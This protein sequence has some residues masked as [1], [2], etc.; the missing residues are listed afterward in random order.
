MR[1]K[2]RK[3]FMSIA[4]LLTFTFIILMSKLSFAA[5][6]TTNATTNLSP[7]TA[8]A[9]FLPAQT[10]AGGTMQ[11]QIDL[12]LSEG[13]HAYLKRFKLHVE[14][15]DGLKLDKFKVTPTVQFFD[16]TSNSKQEGIE[17]AAQ[18]VAT[19]E[20]PESFAD[21]TYDAEFILSYQACTQEHC[22]FPQNLKVPARFSVMDQNLH[23]KTATENSGNAQPA[24]EQSAF[25]RALDQGTLTALIFVFLIGL[26]TSFTPCIYPM[27]P[28]TLAILG[29]RT[30]GQSRMR[31]FT[32]SLAYVL[33][34]ALTYS[35]LGVAA[36]STGSLFGAVLS[37]VYVVSGLALVFVVMGLS[38]YGLF[39]LQAPAIVR[40]RLGA[41][42]TKAGYSGAFATGLIAGVVASP[43]VGPVLVGVLTYIAQTQNRFL[44]FIFL[45]T[46]AMGMGVLFLVLGTF[47][48]LL[49]RVPKAG[50][51]MELVK[52]S[53]GTMMVGVAL[54]YIAPLYPA[55]LFHA[56]LASAIIAISSCYGAFSGKAE[57]SSGLMKLRK[58]LMLMV[59]LIGCAYGI[60]A[61]SEA[62]GIQVFQTSLSGSTNSE[63]LKWKVYSP[64]LLKQAQVNHKP[65]IIDFSADWC[66]ACKELEKF[67]YT[68]TSVRKTGEAFELLA[69]DATE[70][71]STLNELKNNYKIVGLPTL[72]FIDRDGNVQEDLTLIGFEEPPA[73]VK[74]MQTLIDSPTGPK[75]K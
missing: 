17:N 59:F 42:Q 6:S 25:S 7:L 31:G 40:D 74:R 56:L 38:M 36:A 37:N 13:Y 9:H 24:K 28:I 73:F 35:T 55:W 45:F 68:D 44:G 11:L 16:S 19:V 30:Q 61:W 2:D 12:H 18:L 64:A 32:L 15:P 48:Q 58:G 3:Y 22:L 8:A 10:A 65:V 50:R 47:S 26:L 46:F 51:W 4:K 57:L 63:G 67:T 75:V 41:T 62:L 39:E 53:F 14:A 20:V 29:A 43:C 69:V 66:A 27:I 71:S 34:I 60:L 72:I 1:Q 54:Y 70:E 33:G 49:S 5:D 21:K 23:T 52:F